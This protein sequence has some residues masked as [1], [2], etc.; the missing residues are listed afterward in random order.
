MEETKPKGGQTDQEVKARL[1]SLMAARGW[2]Q[3][4]AAEQV[5][6][7]QAAMSRW[8]ANRYESPDAMNSR[9][10]GWLEQ[11]RQA[12]EGLIPSEG[13]QVIQEVCSA[14]QEKRRF[15]VV[16]GPPGNG[17]TEGLKAYERDHDDVLLILCDSSMTPKVL[18]EEIC[19][20]TGGTTAELMRHA[21]AR[22][23][24]RLILIDEADTLPVR[25]LETLRRV[26]DFGRCGM[27]FAGE[28]RLEHLLRRSP[29]TKD[30]LARMYSR[31]DYFVGVTEPAAADV[32]TYLDAHGVTDPAARKLIAQVGGKASFRAADRL[33]QRSKELAALN[34]QQVT[35]AVV[36]LASK[37]V[38]L[39]VR[40]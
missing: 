28:P 34:G 2:S 10:A 36:R 25:S 33:T 32:H 15:G 17:K 38:I 5:G 27:I 4:K 18:L 11:R 6:V 29:G 23:E 13:Y 37:R 7:S 14:C 39:P 21:R 12:W 16:I 9:V 35:E 31:V 1:E 30:N 26:Y 20:E 40:L 8:F 24:G 22:S 19:G 3:R